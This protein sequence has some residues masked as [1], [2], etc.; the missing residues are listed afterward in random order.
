MKSI[1]QIEAEAASTINKQTMIAD[2]KTVSS[3]KT[4]TSRRSQSTTSSSKSR[5]RKLH[6]ATATPEEIAATRHLR[7]VV[8]SITADKALSPQDKAAKMKNFECIVDNVEKRLH[9]SPNHIRGDDPMQEL[10]SAL[11]AASKKN[12]KK[13]TASNAAVIAPPAKKK[14]SLFSNPLKKK[15]N[16]ADA[17]A[18]DS[19]QKLAVVLETLEDARGEVEEQR[20][21]DLGLSEEDRAEPQEGTEKETV[22]DAN[23]YDDDDATCTDSIIDA[24]MANSQDYTASI[25]SIR[26]LGTFEKDFIQNVIAEQQE[27]QFEELSCSTFEKDFAARAAAAGGVIAIPTQVNLGGNR[28]EVTDDDADDLTVEDARSETTFEADARQ[29]EEVEEDEN[30]ELTV[31]GI[32]SETTFEQDAKQQQYQDTQQHNPQQAMPMAQQQQQHQHQQQQQPTNVFIPKQHECVP[33]VQSERSVST[34]EQ[35]TMPLNPRQQV[36]QTTKSVD[37]ARSVSTFEKDSRARNVL[38]VKIGRVVPCSIQANGRKAEPTTPKSVF[39]QGDQSTSTFEKD[40]KVRR[41][42]KEAK[43]VVPASNFAPVIIPQEQPQP[44]QQQQHQAVPPPPRQEQFQQQM[45][46]QLQKQLQQQQKEKQK[47]PFLPPTVI[48]IT[49][50]EESKSTSSVRS[51][52]RRTSTN[53]Q[54]QQQLD[55]SSLLAFERDV[56]R[57]MMSPKNDLVVDLSPM[58]IDNRLIKGKNP[59]IWGNLFS[60]RGFCHMSFIPWG[61]GEDFW[62]WF[63]YRDGMVCVGMQMITLWICAQ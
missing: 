40:F 34:F 3:I 63:C 47:Q 54:E 43:V 45:E 8:E 9:Y 51:K 48:S 38:A 31:E 33:T 22:D 10:M 52:S 56:S 25:C 46:K 18:A 27:A 20:R 16:A 12:A 6:V 28:N 60:G 7:L 36:V 13:G 14:S 23:E 55:D 53:Q 30:D 24:R 5:R 26:S 59:S 37:S 17:A 50:T 57:N 62:R 32:L 44:P 58:A 19:S 11:D 2:D 41:P 1:N 4:G 39:S 15:K 61:E 29:Y 35:D 42:K 21:I 49:K